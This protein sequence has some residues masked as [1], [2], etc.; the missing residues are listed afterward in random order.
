[1][2]DTAGVHFKSTL[3][4]DE[5]IVVEVDPPSNT[6]TVKIRDRKHTWNLCETEKGFEVGEYSW[7]SQPS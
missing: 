4:K 6:L 1:M 7:V 5:I 3:I 2:I